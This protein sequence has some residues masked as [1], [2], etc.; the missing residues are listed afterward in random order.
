M[1]ILIF[2]FLGNKRNNGHVEEKVRAWSEQRVLISMATDWETWTWAGWIKNTARSRA[3]HPGSEGQR[4]AF[5]RGG[6]LAPGPDGPVCFGFMDSVIKVSTAHTQRPWL[7]SLAGLETET[8]SSSWRFPAGC[9]G[10]R[11]WIACI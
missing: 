7:L 2:D 4:T 1:W 10:F 5:S 6:P 11:R 3:H 9:V 8:V